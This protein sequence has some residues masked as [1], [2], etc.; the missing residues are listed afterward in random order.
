MT[1]LWSDCRVA[2]RSLSRSPGFSIAAIA[3][4]A[5]GLAVC[6]TVF[7]II[8]GLVLRQVPVAAPEQIVAVSSV[9][10]MDMLQQEPVSFPDYA[11][12]VREARSFDGV[13]A[14]RRTAG[15]VG[16]GAE[17]RV[18]LGETVTPNYW[19]VLGLAPVVGRGFVSQDDPGSVV[20]L[21]HTLWRQQYGG[22]ATAIGRSLEISGRRRTIVGIAPEGFTGV[23]R[24]IAPDFWIPVDSAGLERSELRSDVAWWVHGRLRA[25]VE[26]AAAAAEV[27]QV[28]RRIAAAHPADAAGRR[29][30]AV[31][32][33]DAAVHPAV[34][35]G[36]LVAGSAGALVLAGLLL[37]VACSN[38]TQLTM[39]RAQ[40]RSQELALRSSLGASRWRIVRLLLLEGVAL[41]LVAGLGALILGAWANSVLSSIKLPIPVR[42]DLGMR[43]D[44]IVLLFL[45]GTTLVSASIFTIGPALRA[46]RVDVM[47]VLN[48]SGARAGTRSLRR[49]SALVV[50]A[51]FCTLLLILGGLAARSL[52]RASAIDPGF[53]IDG[54]YVATA[55]PTLAAYEPARAHTYFAG[56]TAAL[57]RVPGVE[58]VSW[59][60]PVPLSLNIRITRLRMPQDVGLPVQQLPLVD[61][62]IAWPGYF[63]TMGIAVQAGR[64]FND[65]DVAGG[66]SAAIVNETFV[67]R[68]SPGRNPIGQSIEVGFPVPSPVTIVGIVADI[69]SRTLGDAARP[70]VYTTGVQDALGW[71]TATAVVRLSAAGPNTPRHLTEAIRSIGPTVPVYDVQPLS[72]RIAGVL[73]LPRYA[74]A[75]FG[76]VGLIALVLV[77]VGL[78]GV[79]AY[80]AA[81]RTREIGIRVAMGG[82]PVQILWLVLRQSLWPA[83]AG[84]AVGSVLA[85]VAARAMTVLL[86]GISTADPATY[87]ASGV[88]VTLAATAAALPSVL[89]ALRLDPAATL[90]Q[91]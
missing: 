13:V 74:A 58:S 38:V 36:A 48:R 45:A 78:A 61:A 37:L 15:T 66:V 40:G 62:A 32:F 86:Y 77:S 47:T 88:T 23:F 89:R 49:S 20:V 39:A 76:G 46:S 2:V 44:P 34:A 41:S 72:T 51:G 87:V 6:V 68:Y 8:N 29:L 33:A 70:M 26:Q 12:L 35:S 24:G 55:T 60:H 85:L 52:Q 80:W 11:D 50:Q 54:M 67:R 22:D 9:G 14:H 71:Q 43:L 7:S 82:Q 19:Q 73:I 69:R 83:L 18:T 79:V 53:D 25:G 59:V 27:E 31:A 5:T 42:V 57:Q 3:T 63:R 30:R 1:E 4:L 10:E 17:G 91:Q 75:A 16:T 81:Q 84:V 90:R 56:A 64:E 28:G 21:S 65:T